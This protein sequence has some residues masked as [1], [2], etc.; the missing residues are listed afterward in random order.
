MSIFESLEWRYK[1]YLEPYLLLHES[2]PK[3]LLRKCGNYASLRADAPI[4][5]LSADAGNIGDRVSTLGVE[6]LAGARGAELFASRVA[7]QG[8][9][10]ALHRLRSHRPKSRIIIGGGGLLQ[11]C[12]TPFWRELIATGFEFELFGVGA[13]E[14]TGARRLPPDSLMEEIFYRARSL[15]VRDNWT[16]DLIQRNR[17]KAVSVGICPSVNFLVARYGHPMIPRRDYLLYVEHPVDVRMAGG[18]PLRHGAILKEVARRLGLQFDHTDH[19]RQSLDNLMQR[20]QRARY[21]VSSRLH[22]C[23]FSYAAAR[24]FLPI[25]SDQKSAAFV[26]THLPHNPTVS[27]DFSIEEILE[28]LERA[29]VLHRAGFL[30]RLGAA[31]AHNAKAMQEA[32][33][34]YAALATAEA[35]P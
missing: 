1:L 16:R 5:Y 10:K 35:F 11:D 26:A 23:I 14:M 31:L 7:L 28:K 9:S 22:G 3:A 8:T 12:F 18:D 4:C 32:T 19:I 6:Y 13:N 2:V 17:S 29:E 27:V 33:D 30:E 24:P 25:V 15:H 21:V 20:Y 34:R